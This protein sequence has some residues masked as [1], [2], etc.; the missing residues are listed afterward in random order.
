M[1]PQYRSTAAPT[2]MS[3]IRENVLYSKETWE[4]EGH[5]PMTWSTRFITRLL[6]MVQAELVET[7]D[8]DWLVDAVEESSVRISHIE[9][10]SRFVVV[11]SPQL[12]SSS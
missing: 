11:T 2:Q 3:D 1:S 9:G 12:L 7:G 4:G 6:E 5:G 10:I 8:R